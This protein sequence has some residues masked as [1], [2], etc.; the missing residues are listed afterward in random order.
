MEICL[1]MSRWKTRIE[2]SFPVR[3]K[4]MC[5]L[6]HHISI[7]DGGISPLLQIFP[8]AGRVLNRR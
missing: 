5:C 1:G 3:L 4:N 6:T 2:G 7:T 8:P